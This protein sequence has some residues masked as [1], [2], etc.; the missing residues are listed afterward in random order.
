MKSL[1]W[2][3]NLLF[4]IEDLNLLLIFFEH[5]K[6]TVTTL[7]KINF[8]NPELVGPKVNHVN[9][10][11]RETYNSINEI[12][13]HVE[14]GLMGGN[15]CFLSSFAINMIYCHLVKNDPTLLRSV[16]TAWPCG[17]SVSFFFLTPIQIRLI[18]QSKGKKWYLQKL[19]NLKTID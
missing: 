12:Y 14:V 3:I 19:L 10:S 4:Q 16:L 1:F 11:K 17:P 2:I 18:I 6:R 8:H 15:S 5:T 7:I 13:D 9:V